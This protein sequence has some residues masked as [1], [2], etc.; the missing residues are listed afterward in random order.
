MFNYTEIAP[1]L[2]NDVFRTRTL[3]NATSYTVDGRIKPTY[4]FTP[5]PTGFSID[6]GMSRW[7]IQLGAKLSF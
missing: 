3:T 1:N 2:A 7:R 6:N 4:T 5:G